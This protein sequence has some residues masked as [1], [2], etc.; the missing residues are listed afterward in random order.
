MQEIANKTDR[1]YG[2]R[3]EGTLRDRFAGFRVSAAIIMKVKIYDHPAQRRRHV[4]PLH[5]RTPRS[6]EE[7][8]ARINEHITYSDLSWYT[9]F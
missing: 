1:E 7:G 6:I 4:N 5:F 8:V 9:T 3:Y 2:G